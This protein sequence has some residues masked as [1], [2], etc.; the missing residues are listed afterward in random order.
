MADN[1]KPQSWWQTLPGILTGAAAAITAV[2]GLLA[3]LVQQ[4][5]IG[6]KDK[7]ASPSRVEAPSPSGTQRISNVPASDPTTH[8]K[9]SPKTWA[10]T[11]AIITASDGTAT[12]IRAETLSNCISV[13][14]ALDLA[15]GQ[16]IAFEK[17]RRFDVLNA[18]ARFAA[19]SRA[20]VVITL[21]D[22]RT[23]KD[24]VGADCDIFGYND[25]GRFEITYQN[26]KRVEFRR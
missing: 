26:L 9:D 5:V 1:H 19:N 15:S 21:L 25:L 3:I 4:G 11:E 14:H 10:E 2:T 22:G 24:S 18:D 23:I 13:H 7:S 16:S 12:T 20:A 17:M 6:G 8:S